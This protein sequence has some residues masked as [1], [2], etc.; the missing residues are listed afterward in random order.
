MTSI[1]RTHTQRLLKLADILA[2]FRPTKGKRFDMSKWGEHDA[3][4]AP[5][6]Q[7]GFCGTAACALGHAAMDP[8]FRRAGL[9]MRWQL[10]GRVLSYYGASIH[11]KTLEGEFAGA[12]FFGLSPDE[13]CDVFLGARRS[14]NQVVAVLRQ[15]AKK[16]EELET[17]SAV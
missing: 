8:G 7:D 16:R 5:T 17:D 11:F 14:K 15:Y 6:P 13:A 3:S 12:K 4:H 2:K 1:Q 9:E 10:H